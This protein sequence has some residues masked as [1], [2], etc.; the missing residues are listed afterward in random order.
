VKSSRRKLHAG[1]FFLALAAGLL[2][3]PWHSGWTWVEQA[4]AQNIGQR[5]V[6]GKVI[7][8]DSV[9]VSGATVFL[10]NLKSKSIRS[11]TT[12]P[13]GRFRFTQVNMAED[14]EIWAEKADKKSAVK[15]ISSWDARKE[16][17]CEL[18]L[19]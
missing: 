2:P 5:V 3:A 6:L 12:E 8:S 15:T 9:A 19:K 17:E 11:Y 1:A 4:E 10:R 7:D 14:Y 18:K 13:D 16:F